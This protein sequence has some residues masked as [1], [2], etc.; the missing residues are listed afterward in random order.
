[1]PIYEY[2]CDRCGRFETMQRITDDPLKKC[3]TCKRRVHK[4]I[5]N[6]SFQLKGSG[7][8]ITDY[9][10]AKSDGEKGKT[11]AGGEAA[12]DSTGAKSGDS[13]SES[14]STASEGGAKS[15]SKDSKR[16]KSGAKA[17]A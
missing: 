8:Y 9:A 2:Q 15:K 1:M 6:T 7:W 13:A 3:P 11:E 17:A 14:K 16:G 4:L 10:R 12:G 5:S